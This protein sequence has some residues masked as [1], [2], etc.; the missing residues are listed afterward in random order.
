M[1]RPQVIVQFVFDDIA[2]RCAAEG[3][4]YA[5]LAAGFAAAS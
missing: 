4:F 3:A 1:T 2:Q 5:D